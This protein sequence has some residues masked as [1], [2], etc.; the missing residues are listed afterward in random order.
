MLLVGVATGLHA[1]VEVDTKIDSLSILIGEQ[2]Q[3]E[4]GVSA[5]K[6]AVT[7]WPQWKPQQMLVPGLEVLAVADLDTTDLGDGRVRTGKVLTLTSFDEKLYAIPGIKVK[8]DGK[9]YVGNTLALKVL[10]VDVDTLHPNQFF[11]PKEVQQNPFDWNEW[12]TMMWM[13]FLFL[14]LVASWVYLYVR[15]K[16]NKPI[17]M[18]IRI[19]KR[20]LPHQKAMKAI[21][22]IKASHLQA[23]DDQKAYYTE[24]TDTLRQY[25]FERFGFNAMEMT[26]A[27][28]IEQLRQTGDPT[29]I[30]ELNDLFRTADLVKFA[31]YATLLNE[32]DLN[33]VHA[34]KFIDQT[35]RE[36]MPEEERIKPQLSKEDKQQNETRKVIK[37]LLWVVAAAAVALC[38]FVVYGVYELLR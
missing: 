3:L 37:V 15:L 10:T 33:L 6:G 26:S 31:K 28:I 18:P 17:V 1:Q 11:P 8:V 13:S 24:L 22:K 21:D 14:L 4:V 9:E 12:S 35:K 20:V 34:I 30:Q 29:M 36:D 23:S 27:E 25:I 19:V 7:V 38:G 16:Q 5:R 2:T 32:N